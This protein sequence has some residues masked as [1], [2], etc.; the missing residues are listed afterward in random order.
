MIT[1]GLSEK[2]IKQRQ[3]FQI[4]GSVSL[5]LGNLQHHV[6]PMIRTRI[7]DLTKEVVDITLQLCTLQDKIK[8]EWKEYEN[9][10]SS[11]A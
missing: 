8:K 7:P 9:H 3:L 4:D 10:N 5:C 1:K 6:L 11:K 2:Q